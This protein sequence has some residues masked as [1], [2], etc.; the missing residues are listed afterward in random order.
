MYT[1]L[2]RSHLNQHMNILVRYYYQELSDGGKDLHLGFMIG[3]ALLSNIHH[4]GHRY[5]EKSLLHNR[6]Q[7]AHKESNQQI[8][9]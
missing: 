3:E 6:S 1:P 7:I 4:Y 8:H 9:H 5:N 2:H